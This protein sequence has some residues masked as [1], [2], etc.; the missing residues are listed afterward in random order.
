LTLGEGHSKSKHNLLARGN[1]KHARHWQNGKRQNLVNAAKMLQLT[2]VIN[3]C[4]VAHPL[5][6][7][8]LRQILQKTGFRF[9]PFGQVAQV[10]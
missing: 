4:P 1:E 3:F 6:A 7:A 8:F 9:G 5:A 10:W 2:D